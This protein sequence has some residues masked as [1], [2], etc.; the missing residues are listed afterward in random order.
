MGKVGV[1]RGG[2]TAGGA[3]EGREKDFMGGK[4]FGLEGW[5][6]LED[7][8]GLGDSAPTTGTPVT[9]ELGR[10]AFILVVGFL[11]DGGTCTSVVCVRACACACVCV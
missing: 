6:W 5:V 11:G 7:D 4:E 1:V 9:M 8:A 10:L 3:E 2:E